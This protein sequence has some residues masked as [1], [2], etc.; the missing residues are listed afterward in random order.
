MSR[1][2]MV[3]AAAALAASAVFAAE[4]VPS[5]GPGSAQHK[6]LRARCAAMP[7]THAREQCMRD[8]EAAAEKA[9]EHCADLTL[10]A[11]QQCLSDV[12]ATQQQ[13][14]DQA[15]GGAQ[16]GATTGGVPTPTTASPGEE[17][18]KQ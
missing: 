8:A 9:G 3:W 1:W 11:R 14:R 18:K 7:E 6:A 10:R 4:Q 17:L 2:S 15:A 12:Q 5:V 16:S 13:I